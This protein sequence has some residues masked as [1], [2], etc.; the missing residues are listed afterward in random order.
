MADVPL[1]FGRLS[2]VLKRN[3][4]GPPEPANRLDW[5]RSNQADNAAAPNEQPASL[6]PVA[7]AQLADLA[8]TDDVLSLNGTPLRHDR[9]RDLGYVEP[10]AGSHEANPLPGMGSSA[11]RLAWGSAEMAAVDRL[12]RNHP[13]ARLL[14]NIILPAVHAALAAHNWH[15]AA[16]IGANQDHGNLSPAVPLPKPLMGD[17]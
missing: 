3:Y 15:V 12:T 1:T 9:Y 14:A 10:V 17:H 7:L 13:T 16:E 11:G 6:L 2:E 4:A 5:L 8:S